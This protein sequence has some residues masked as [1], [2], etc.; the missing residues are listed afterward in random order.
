MK[1]EKTIKT[2]QR[3]TKSGKITTVKSHTAKYDAAAEVAKKA[4]RKKGAGGELKTRLTKMPDPKLELQNYLDE[5]KKSRSGASSDTTKTKKP[6][7]KKKLKKPVGGGIT[8]LEPKESKKAPAK[9]QEKTAPKSSGLSSTEFKAWY[10]DPKSKEGKAAAKKLKE[11]VGAEKYKELNKKANDSYSSRGHISLFKSI[12]SDST[13][14]TAPKKTLKKPVGGGITGLEPKKKP[15]SSK[16]TAKEKK[17]SWTKTSDT[18]LRK[19]GDMAVG[20]MN[21]GKRS[22]DLEVR[23]TD[24]GYEVSMYDRKGNIG[25]LANIHIKT[26]SDLS[27]HVKSEVDP[28]RKLT[29]KLMDSGEIEYGTVRVKSKKLKSQEV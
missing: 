20:S 28:K 6:A 25:H 19:K 7:P 23:P 17:S 26:L 2:Y 5:L 9:K 21:V 11:Q 1:K 15:T 22:I 24:K 8:G 18:P 12:G 10:H 29:S 16:A 14:K 13:S 27:K 4:A 3:K